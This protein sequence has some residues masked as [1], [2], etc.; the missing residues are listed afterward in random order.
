MRREFYYNSCGSGRIHA[1]RWVPEGA[2][3]AVMQIVHGISEH[4]AR[5]EEYAEYLNG[6]G[7]L[8]VAQDHMGHGLSIGEDRLHGYFHGGWF[9]AVEDTYQLLERTRMEYPKLPYVLL[10]HSMGSFLARSILAEHPDSGISACI[11]CGTAWENPALLRLAVPACQVFCRLDGEQAP[12]PMLESLVF[13]SYNRRVKEPRT[14][15]DWINSSPQEVDGFVSDPLCGF[16][17]SAGLMRDM[18]S[19]LEYT[20]RRETLANMDKELPVLFASGADD[21]VGAYGRGVTQAAN[22]FQRAGMKDITEQLFP[23]ARH[24]ILREARKDQVYAYLTGWMAEKAGT[25]REKK[26]E[27]FLN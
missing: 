11:L 9:S 21:P 17:V 14:I 1:W 10:G 20:E 4:S 6:L 7:F 13:G 19:G 8:V 5:Y 26:K 27:N 23:N 2:P 18:L 25:P 15:Y 3:K 16:I 12:N 22:A 24:E